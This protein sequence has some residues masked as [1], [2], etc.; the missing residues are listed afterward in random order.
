MKITIKDK[1][2]LDALKKKYHYCSIKIIAIISCF[3]TL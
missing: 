2:N 3:I 1:Q